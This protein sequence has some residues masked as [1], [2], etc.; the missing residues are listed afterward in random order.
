[1]ITPRRTRLVRVPD[2]HAF[3]R[4]IV[5]CSTEGRSELL[6]STAVVVPTRGAAR[7]LR[8]RFALADDSSAAAAP[9][10]LTRDDLYSLLNARLAAPLT[11]LA[12]CEREVILHSAAAGAIDA[13]TAP[14]FHLR[15][16]LV[17][18]MMRFYDQLRRQG[19]AVDRYEELLVGALDAESDRGAE[20]LLRQ[21]HF[22]AAA[23]RA[24]EH[25]LASQNLVDEHVLRAHLLQITAAEPL[26]RMV[27]AV[28][29]W[30]ADA[31]GLFSA[32]FDLLARLPGLEQLDIVATSGLLRSGF[33]QR[34]QDWLPGIEQIDQIDQID[35]S[36]GRD[37][38]QTAS[39]VPR[40]VAPDR[41]DGS[42]VWVRRDREEELV[43][44]ARR[45]NDRIGV[46]FARAAA[47]SLSRP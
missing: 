42:P 24:Y 22:L 26:R 12:A 4:A 32:D 6:R 11:L 46:V 9:V 18:E 2:L 33:D 7:H 20:R 21:T 29:D 36:Q 14:P 44:V 25:R 1:M 28:G 27:V 5:A 8:R 47:V 38:G 40:L 31:H 19:Q 13:G 37:A 17:A 30:I 10:I 16:G 34:V 35:A 39:P 23:Y 41:E 3:R 15:A 43:A 45:A